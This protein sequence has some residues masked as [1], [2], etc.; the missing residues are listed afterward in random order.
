MEK[1]QVIHLNGKP[2]YYPNDIKTFDELK[3]YIEKFTQSKVKIITA[4]GIQVFDLPISDFRNSLID[5]K[6][7]ERCKKCWK[8][9][10]HTNSCR[11]KTYKEGLKAKKYSMNTSTSINTDNTENDDLFIEMT[12][13]ES[14]QKKE[15][16]VDE[17]KIIWNTSASKSDKR[18]VE[19][20]MLDGEEILKRIRKS[21][22]KINLK[23]AGYVVDEEKIRITEYNS[24][25][26]FICYYN[27]FLRINL[28][29]KT[30][31]AFKDSAQ[32][33]EHDVIDVE[34]KNL[35]LRDDKG[36]KFYL[37]KNDEITQV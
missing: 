28:L 17:K 13:S 22:K 6:T 3:T 27:S 11:Q 18:V 2:T 31:M 33:V 14:H 35:Y 23:I 29:C 34:D 9:E 21:A 5:V 16:K 32:N 1:Y 24:R 30:L 15:I 25:A 7:H 8:H 10:G 26:S 36:K 12:N 4:D 37:N 20:K 19:K